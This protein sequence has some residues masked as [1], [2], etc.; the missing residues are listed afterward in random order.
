MMRKGFALGVALLAGVG[1]GSAD[2]H[3]VDRDATG[4]GTGASWADAFTDLQ[5][6]LAASQSGDEIWVAEG[7]YTPAP[8]G[9]SVA[10]FELR[11]GVALYGGFAGIEEFP[12]QRNPGIHPTVLSGDVGRDD[13]VAPGS[14][15]PN[16]IRLET[17]NSGHVVVGSGVGRGAVLDGFVITAGAYGP[18]GTPAGDP[19]LYGSGLYIVDG[20]P[21][22]RGCTII[23]NLAGFGPGAGAFLWNSNAAFDGCTFERNYVHLGSGGAIYLGGTSEPEITG[24]TFRQNVATSYNGSEGQGGA[25]ENRSTSAFAISRCVFEFNEARPL[26]AGSYEIPRGGGISS[27]AFET[28]AVIRDC[29][30]RQNRAAY[31]AGVFVWNPTTV[32]NCVFDRNTAFV[33]AGQ[34]GVSVGGD[35]AGLAAQWTDVSLINS[36]VVSNSGQEGAGLLEI[37]DPNSPTFNGTMHLRNTI[38]WGNIANGED[39]DPLDRQ[40][41]GDFTAY[42]SCIQDLL[43]PVPGEDPPDPSHFPG[44]I[45][46]DPRLTA[47]GDLRLSDLSP[48]IDAGR[49]SDVPAG[50]VTDVDGAPR[51]TDDPDVPDTGLGTPPLVDMGAYERARPACLGDVNSDR[52]VDLADLATL[53]SH[54][55]VPTGST[56]EHGDLDGDGDVDI[57]DLAGLLSVF[58]SRCD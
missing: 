4:G 57:S 22:V 27:F 56:F 20:S 23:N 2:V 3:Y 45:V 16:N 40:L 34:G 30:F 9:D 52:A 13:W 44:C 17:A 28:P 49:N 54:F 11:D 35:G 42:F 33:Y 26:S 19:L 50:V 14:G 10:S 15:W 7:V 47:P 58:G 37:S 6:A 24:C 8:P 12:T 43:T 5:S 32:I 1:R 41:R 55:G 39:V 36:T 46:V 18:P 38:V 31:G 48:C 21:T 53:L 29:V 51:F 25:I